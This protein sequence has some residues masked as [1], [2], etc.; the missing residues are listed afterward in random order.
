MQKPKNA[1]GRQLL[2]NFNSITEAE[3]VFLG[4]KFE[5]EEL[6]VCVRDWCLKHGFM[7]KQGG[8]VY[9]NRE[10]EV[11]T[12]ICKRKSCNYRL[13]FLK[14]ATSEFYTLDQGRSTFEHNHQ[15]SPN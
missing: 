2:P 13:W 15:I 3:E 4:E 1:F 9:R 10:G 5:K 12:W 6:G 7:V 14:P 8:G 11:F